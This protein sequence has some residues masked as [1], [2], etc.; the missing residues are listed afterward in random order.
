[1]EIK[2]KHTG[3]GNG[4]GTVKDEYYQTMKESLRQAIQIQQELGSVIDVNRIGL[5]LFIQKTKI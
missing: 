1:M 3:N 4:N 5:S 2:I